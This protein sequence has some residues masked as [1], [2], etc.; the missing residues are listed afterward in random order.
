MRF[1]WKIVSVYLKLLSA[2][3]NHQGVGSAWLHTSTSEPSIQLC[4]DRT[5]KSK[6][7]CIALEGEHVGH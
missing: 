2:A 6:V 1:R 3:S 4:A 7:C 5:S